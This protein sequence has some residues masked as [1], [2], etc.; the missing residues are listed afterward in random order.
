MRTG[1]DDAAAVA[2]V[3]WL[4]RQA[5]WT[6]RASASR[7]VRVRLG[8]GEALDVCGVAEGAPGSAETLRVLSGGRKVFLLRG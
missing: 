2:E 7:V 6:E 8:D 4:E 1:T 5:V 3:A